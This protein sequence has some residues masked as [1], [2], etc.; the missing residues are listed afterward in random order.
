LMRDQICLAVSPIHPLARRRSV[1]VEEIAREPLI[2]YSRKEYPDYHALIENVF[3]KCKT[4]PR[5]AEEHDG[6]TSLIT[7]VESGCGVALVTES[8]SCTSGPRLKLIPLSPAMEPSVVG[9]A[10]PKTGITATGNRFL[11][12]AREAAHRLQS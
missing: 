10:W 12:C 9:V 11:E 6:V 2:A 7:A 1:M 4:K 5:I 8:L 3:A